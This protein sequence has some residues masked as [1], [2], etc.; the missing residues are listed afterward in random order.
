MKKLL[1]I[2]LC[3]MFCLGSAAQNE[4]ENENEVVESAAL[5]ASAPAAPVKPAR[6]YMPE[7][8]EQEQQA[9]GAQLVEVNSLIAQLKEL[10]LNGDSLADAL[11]KPTDIYKPVRGKSKFAR[12]HHIY[13]T[14]DISPSVSVDKDPDLPEYTSNGQE[15]DDDQVASP[16][17]VGLNFGYS[18]IF[19][20]GHEENGQLR[21]NRMG[22]AYN[23]G[24]LASFSRQ[25]KYGTTCNFLLKSGI[26]TGNGHMMGIGFDVLGGYGKSAGDTYLMVYEENDEDDLATP[27]TEWCWQYGAQLWMRS[28]LLHT[29]IR[30][31]E[32]LIFARFIRSV[33]P[34]KYPPSYIDQENKVSFENYWKDE[35]WSFG[36]TFRYKF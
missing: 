2:A 25:D 19:V 7:Y 21:L 11:D 15:V 31:V 20:P 24:L 23:V 36:V 13:Q 22:F 1:F 6:K 16:T 32:M 34:D 28:N 30:N 33:N 18:L 29:A 26:E 9:T 8:R 3:A 35:S 14:L 10:T 4:N 17:G 5:S 12:R 27:Y